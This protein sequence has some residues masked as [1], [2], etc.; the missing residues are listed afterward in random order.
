MKSVVQ[1]VKFLV[2][3]ILI[4]GVQKA[5]DAL[6]NKKLKS[7]GPIISFFVREQNKNVG[8]TQNG[9]LMQPENSY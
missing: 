7:R 9:K 5:I 8:P 4:R 2:V 3:K 6:R 1:A